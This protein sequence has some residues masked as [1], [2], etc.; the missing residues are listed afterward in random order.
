MELPLRLAVIGA[1]DVAYRDYLPHAGRIATLG[2]V[3]LVIAR[4]RD[5]ADKAARD[6]GI[7]RAAIDW[8]EALDAG[9]DA[10]I[11]LTPIP[12]HGAINLALAEAGK[13]FYSEKPLAG[14][15]AEARRIIA[16]AAAS[17]AVIAAAPSVMVYPQVTR[18]AAILA[19]GEIGPVHS[20]RLNATTPPPP[21]AGYVGD[22]RP[23]FAADAG[24]LVDMGVYPLH[25]LT[26][27]FGAVAEVAAI[28]HRTRQD[29]TVGDGPFA[30]ETVP[31]DVD[32]NWQI[33]LALQ[34]GLLASLQVAFC[35]R[36]PEGCAIDIAGEAG[37]LTVQLLDPAAPIRVLGPSGARSEPVAAERTDGPDHILGVQEF[38]R[39]VAERRTP[40]I[41][42][43][44][45]LH[46]L[47]VIAAA[48]QSA[49]TGR[50]VAVA[51]E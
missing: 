13:P 25:A 46:V 17:G 41:G 28:A 29:F 16:A 8:R 49:A 48:R 1:G 24:P 42:A 30:G 23:F 38:L 26:G 36:Q 35:V 32:D 51:E 3:D 40:A 2:R 19:S 47:A 43:A 39:A 4:H 22:H 37:S 20:V 10:V 7:A 31:I 34:G 27:L 5:R 15:A 6:F 44:A 9:I 18:A 11:N 14:T 45:A 50:R 21:W 33:A 12:A